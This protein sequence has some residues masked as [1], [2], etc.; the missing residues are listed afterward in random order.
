VGR[1]QLA[2]QVVRAGDQGDGP[3]ARKQDLTRLVEPE[4][5]IAC[6]FHEVI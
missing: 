6:L 4:N 5:N 1:Q 3:L 2:L